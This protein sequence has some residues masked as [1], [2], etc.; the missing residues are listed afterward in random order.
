MA[1]FLQWG[2]KVAFL[3]LGKMGWHMA[4]ALGRAG[5]QV[6][7][8]SRSISEA[9]ANPLFIVS[10]TAAD[11]V[12]E[13]RAVVMC[14]RDQYVTEHVLFGTG[15][16]NAIQQGAV[17]IDTGTSGPDAARAHA[18]RLSSMG[19]SYIDA[20]VSGGT[21]GAE[22]ASL[23]IFV[24]GSPET[25][26]AVSPLLDA[27]GRPFHLGGVGAGQTAKLANQIIVGVTIAAV[28]EGLAFAERNGIQLEQ[29]LPALANG[30][31]AS[32]VLDV[33]GPRIAQKDFSA[34]GAVRLHL[35]DLKLAESNKHSLG[36][37]HAE[38]VRQGF[39]KLAAAGRDGLDHSAYAKL[40][41]INPE[42]A[43]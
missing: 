5:F 15:I 39:E 26:D 4:N 30:F 28:A 17:V 8:W 3:G 34:P 22:N 27:M 42:G 12:H 40:Y 23:S 13:A 2:D 16:C 7:G 10:P 18:E 38:L 31:A 14:L 9:P 11:A 20:P 19:V 6:A 33:H 36:L 1:R 32:R 37:V 24:G 29:I 41:E 35:K 21:V 25:V 43:L